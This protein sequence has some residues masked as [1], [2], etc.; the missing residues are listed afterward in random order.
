MHISPWSNVKQ[1]V[2]WR[3]VIIVINRRGDS[4]REYDND[5]PDGFVDVTH[6]Q[7]RTRCTPAESGNKRRAH[8]HSCPVTC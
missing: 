3:T 6:G 7:L 8:Q 5:A 1:H 4:P 2:L